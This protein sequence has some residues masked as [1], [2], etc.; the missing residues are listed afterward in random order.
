M[1]F[2][3]DGQ[4]RI[5]DRPI[6]LGSTDLSS[7]GRCGIGVRMTPTWKPL[8]QGSSESV[9][10]RPAICT[11]TD[12]SKAAAISADPLFHNLV[13]WTVVLRIRDG[14]FFIQNHP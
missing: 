7:G 11:C 5:S 8:A 14:R 13:D 6:C 9:D 12:V 10:A 1:T 4:H 2:V 3:I